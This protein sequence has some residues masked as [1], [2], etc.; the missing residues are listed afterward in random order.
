MAQLKETNIFETMCIQ[1]LLNTHLT[2]PRHDIDPPNFY[3]ASLFAEKDNE[4]KIR[5]LYK[6]S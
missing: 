6:S 5:K 3:Q 1:C 2:Q 4:R